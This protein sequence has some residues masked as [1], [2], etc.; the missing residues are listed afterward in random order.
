[1]KE[2]DIHN[3]FP[4]LKRYYDSSATCQ[5]YIQ[6]IQNDLNQ[7]YSKYKILPLSEK[8][9]TRNNASQPFS[10]LAEITM[11]DTCRALMKKRHDILENYELQK[12]YQ[13][14]KNVTKKDI[15]S[16]IK[17][18]PRLLNQRINVLKENGKYQQYC[19]SE[20]QSKAHLPGMMISKGKESSRNNYR[21]QYKSKS[22]AAIPNIG[23]M[24]S[25][26]RATVSINIISAQQ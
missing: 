12:S 18:S 7:P 17:N 10:K 9:K 22:V 11:T 24:Q 19:L 26:N 13:V 15:L 3:Q 4:E 2:E 25:Q 21:W 23:L 14:Y 1:M 8:F 20:I 16:H 5:H 6:K